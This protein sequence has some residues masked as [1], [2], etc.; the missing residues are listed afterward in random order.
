VLKEEECSLAGAD[1]K[2]LLHFLALLAAKGRV[3]QDDVEAVFLFEC[4]AR[5]FGERVGMD[6]VRASIPCRIMFM[7][8]MT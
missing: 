5:F 4:P 7:I 2:V 3:G 6:Y 8:A 1:G